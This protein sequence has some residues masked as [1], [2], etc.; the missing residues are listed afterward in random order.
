MENTDDGEARGGDGGSA[1][2][3]GSGALWPDLASPPADPVG[4]VSGATEAERAASGSCM[5]C[6]RGEWR[7]RALPARRA[8]RRAARRTWSGR[9]AAQHGPRPARQPGAVAA[10]VGA[11]ATAPAPALPRAPARCR[12]RMACRRKARPAAR[13]RRRPVVCEVV[14]AGHAA[15][16]RWPVA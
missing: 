15:M 4:A 2:G 12:C 14:L 10:R 5:P 11:A 16:A 13:A 6:R 9:R 8:A 3:G 7:R 1:W